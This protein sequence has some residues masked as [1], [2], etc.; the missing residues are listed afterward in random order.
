MDKQRII[1]TVKSPSPWFKEGTE[2]YDYDYDYSEKQRMTFADFLL[3]KKTGSVLVRGVMPDGSIDGEY[4][5]V[6]DFDLSFE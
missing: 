4:C 5:S 3:H 2:V 1:L 6:N